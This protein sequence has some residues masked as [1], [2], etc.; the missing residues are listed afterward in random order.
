MLQ[1]ERELNR[2]IWEAVQLGAY[3]RAMERA[4]GQLSKSVETGQDSYELR[5]E[6]EKLLTAVNPL[7]AEI[8]ECACG[9]SK[10]DHDEDGC[11]WL[12]CR[13]ICGTERSKK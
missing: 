6:I 13:P 3:G 4:L 11:L 1:M 12:G 7:M 8:Y 2:I 9:H 5:E 10:Y